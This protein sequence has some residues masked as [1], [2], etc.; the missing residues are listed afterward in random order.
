[1][2]DPIFLS[3]KERI[4]AELKAKRATIDRLAKTDRQYVLRPGAVCNWA[5]ERDDAIIAYEKLVTKL[6][7]CGGNAAGYAKIAERF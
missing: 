2:S 1:M 3:V 4:I 6:S 5:T 7:L